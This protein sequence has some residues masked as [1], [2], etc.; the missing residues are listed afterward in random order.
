MKITKFLALFLVLLALVA[1][2]SCKKDNGGNT[3][4]P[5]VEPTPNA[6][7]CSWSVDSVNMERSC[8][9][10]GLVTYSCS[11]GKVKTERSFAIGHS[12]GE[13]KVASEAKCDAFGE[14]ERY[15]SECGITEKRSIDK[16]SH[17]YE[18]TEAEIE[19]V[20][21]STYFC[22]ICRDTFS[23]ESGLVES[24]ENIKSERLSDIPEDFSF[25]VFCLEDE[26]Y[27]RENLVIMDTYYEGSEDENKSHYE[28]LLED[29][30][31]GYWLVTP[32]ENYKAGVT[33]K[34]IRSGGVVFVEYGLGDLIFT[35]FREE[36]LVADLSDGIIFLSSL[37]QKN[38][39]FYPYSLEYSEKSGNYWLTLG[40]ADGLEVGDILCVGDAENAEDVKSLSD[41]VFGKISLI[42]YSV[43]ESVYYLLLTSP[44]LGEI[45][46]KL[47]I[48]SSHPELTGDVKFTEE[49]ELY[50]QVVSALYSSKD[51]VDFMGASYVTAT[52]LMNNRGA[53][54][55]VGTFTEFL[56]SIKI[57]K[58]ES[59]KPEL[60]YETGI[61][62]A[63]VVIDGEVSI[64]VTVTSYG[65]ERNVG[66][67]VIS[68]KAYVYLDY[69]KLQVSLSETVDARGK[70]QTNYK[71][72]ISQSVTTGFT[73][74]VA[75]DVDY[76]L[77]AYP[78]VVNKRSSCYHF[79]SCIHVA[80]MNEENAEYITATEL[81]E[82]INKGELDDDLECGTCRP[83]SSM[84]SDNYVLNVS[85]KKIHLVDCKH[86]LNTNESD[87]A[88][89]GAAYGNLELAGYT[90]CESCKPYSKYTNSFSEAL[91]NKMEN[92]DFGH[93]VKEIKEASDKAG[94]EE[95]RKRLLIAEMPLA[96]GIV[97]AD[98]ELYAFVNFT[99]EASLTYKFE[100]TDTSE[101]GVELKSKRFVPYET[102]K[103]TT[104]NEHSLEV[105]GETRLEVGAAFVA[106]AYIVGL[107][108]WMYASFNVEVGA[109]ALANGAL[110]LDWVSHNDSYFAA[111]FES[112]FILNIYFEGKIPFKDTYTYVFYEG[113]YP[114]F[115]LGYS[116]VTHKFTS[117]PE[118]ILLDDTFL[119][120]DMPELMTV[121][122]Y[123]V[124]NMTPGTEVLNYLGVAGR[125][126][127]DYGF[128]D[129]G[130]CFI[131]N[132]I[133]YVI[134]PSISFVDELVIT[135]RGYDEWDNFRD[136]NTKFT[137]PTVSIPI[138]YEA[139]E[140][141]LAYDIS[142]DRTYYY[143]IG[144]GNYSLGDLVIPESYND[145]PVL[146]I[147]RHAF[148]GC[149]TITSVTIPDTMEFMDDHAFYYC[150]NLTSIVIGNGIEILSQ[151]VFNV[152]TN[153]SYIS[154][155]NNVKIIGDGAF[156]GCSYVTTVIIPDSVIEIQGGAFSDCFELQTVVVGRNVESFGRHAFSGCR[157]LTNIYIPKTLTGMGDNVF[158]Y[159]DNLT[160]IYYQGS[161]SDMMKIQTDESNIEYVEKATVHFNY[162]Y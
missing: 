90:P 24:I 144:I 142:G 11:C 160:N 111:Y 86:L 80:S 152:C 54:A 94:T 124:V 57:N 84:T 95:A 158:Y 161:E 105:V 68:F 28:Y 67:I 56:N 23:I 113:D 30:G 60:D 33:Y 74:S 61:I 145:K 76:S 70:S 16:T 1:L 42:N 59:Q 89:S 39:G 147:E 99:L 129:G 62:T 26:S 32:K 128:V 139:G 149:M 120:L 108:K 35:I 153:V 38:P 123:D 21:F 10:D 65:S 103:S 51:F 133:L 143:V 64:P 157:N 162:N 40:K 106:R 34:A 75:I 31:D 137:L 14:E 87:L 43:D 83:I 131:E 4:P 82:R 112:G 78:Y 3:T 29:M 96:F 156:G 7:V 146:G 20:M 72:G 47:D 93:N 125:Y 122:Y 52:E 8:T 37:E 141:M 132:G 5:D 58:E 107:E 41:A 2:G 44:D 71:F 12:F 117:L 135:V 130:N 46:D 126:D 13:W 49:D 150:E 127:V 138:V 151:G 97:R 15:C 119:L 140:N 48:H 19:G 36:S 79:A 148:S 121:G 66:N 25:T 110:R 116:K 115:K 136:G 73:F 53:N 18:I 63:K 100:R 69:A 114:Q 91:M 6:H 55:K 45:F 118:Y 102:D 155:G 27:V 9:Q 159:C 92:G 109:Y 22:V 81:L 154:I 77:E 88:I 85:S 17:K 104:T 50:S 134:D 98:I 101:Y